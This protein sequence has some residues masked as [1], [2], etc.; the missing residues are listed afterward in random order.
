MKTILLYG[1][2]AKQFGRVHRY[3]VRTPA[4]AIRALRV[5]LPGFANAIVKDRHYRVSVAGKDSLSADRMG[6]PTSERDSIRIAPVITGA[7]EG[8][9]LQTIIGAVLI[10]VDYFFFDGTTGLANVG[11]AMVLGGVS[12]MLFA[13]PKPKSVDRPDNTASYAFDG[14]VNTAAQGNPVPICYGRLLV[15]SQVVSAGLTA[16]QI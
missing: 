4:E 3:D 16:E 10:V 8:G 5:T 9:L 6:H 15:G 13:P 14:A 2:L 12:Q 11:W 1:H 7:K